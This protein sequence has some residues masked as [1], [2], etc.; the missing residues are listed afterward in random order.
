M[1]FTSILHG[2]KIYSTLDLKRALNQIDI[3]PDDVEKTEVI[4]PFGLFEYTAMCFG[5]SNAAQTFQRYADPAL[6]DLW[7]VFVYIDDILIAS[8]A[9]LQHLKQLKIVLDRLQT[10]G[11]QLN[12]SKWV[13][14]KPQETFL[15]FDITNLQLRKFK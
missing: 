15:G 11:L 1:D 3:N 14:A 2:T 4:T 6:G 12:L 13:I 5:L 7:F 8:R 10:F 9:L